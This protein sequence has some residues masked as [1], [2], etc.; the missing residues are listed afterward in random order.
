MIGLT[1]IT[2][3]T[4][5]AGSLQKSIDKMASSAVSAD[6][7]VSMANGNSLSPDVEKKLTG[8]D[9]VTDVSPLRNAPSRIDRQTEYLT[10]V[11]GAAIGKL[12]DLTVKDGSFTVGG[13]R[14][15]VDADTAAS[16]GWKAYPPSASPT[17]TA[18][19]RT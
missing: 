2:G 1:L 17:R 5:M 8:A 7:V 18:S 12:T 15:V 16:H 6:Y 3:M 19:G 13:P 14:V 4:V 9:G 11:N 10:G